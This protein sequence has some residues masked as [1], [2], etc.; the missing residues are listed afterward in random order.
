[1]TDTALTVSKSYKNRLNLW[2]L[3]LPVLQDTGNEQCSESELLQNTKK[4]GNGV[5]L[6][7]KYTTKYV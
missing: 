2:P 7:I 3:S 4:E 1:M 5:M 6:C